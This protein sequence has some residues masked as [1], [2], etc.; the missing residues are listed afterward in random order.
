MPR[1]NLLMFVFASLAPA[2]VIFDSLN[3]RKEETIPNTAGQSPGELS[4]SLLFVPPLFST[5]YPDDFWQAIAFLA[6]FS[7]LTASLRAILHKAGWL[8]QSVEYIYLLPGSCLIS[9]VIYFIFYH[10]GQM[11]DASIDS[12]KTGT[13][14]PWSPDKS[15]PWVIYMAGNLFAITR[16]DSGGISSAI[17]AVILLFNFLPFFTG[18]FWI[19]MIAG[20]SVFSVIVQRLSSRLEDSVRG[21]FVFVST[22]AYLTATFLSVFVY[23]VL[24]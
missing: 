11:H 15:W 17:L 8:R 19:S 14:T 23:A 9:I 6:S 4:N 5:L 12:F 22:I 2:L 16:K 18:Y 13:V 20:F 3:A 7:L 24:Y 21:S 1:L 10:D